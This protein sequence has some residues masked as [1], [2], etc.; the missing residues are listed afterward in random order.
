MALAGKRRGGSAGTTRKW[1]LTNGKAI[2]ESLGAS[3]YTVLVV[4]VSA[5]VA[6]ISLIVYAVKQERIARAKQEDEAT[7]VTV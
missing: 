2:L 7:P 5:A 1:I 3:G 4:L 6:W